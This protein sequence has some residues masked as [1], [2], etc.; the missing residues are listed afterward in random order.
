M[1]IASLDVDKLSEAK[2]VHGGAGSLVYTGLWNQDDFETP[3]FFVHAGYIP[4]G[5]GIGHHRH[6]E[7][8]EMF[9]ILD[10]S[11]QFTHN[12]RTTRAEGPAMVPC[13]KGESHAI[14][15]HT[16]RNTR[17]M[18][19]C[20]ANPGGGYDCTD[21]GEDMADAPLE[22]TDRIP[23]GRFGPDWVEMIAKMHGGKNEVGFYRVWEPRDFRT[24]W[25]WMDY[26]LIP[27]DASIGYHRHDTI[28][29][30]Y[31]LIEGSG[32]IAVDD[33]TRD[34]RQGDTIPNRLGG[35]H[36]IYNHTKNPLELLV[37]CVSMTKWVFD[38][39]DHGDDLSQR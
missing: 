22:S 29:E 1:R 34:V 30:C 11:A 36:G 18:N 31:I 14:Y 39:T 16:N 6:D 15:N 10:N 25:S 37:M 38:A 8:E 28:E 35:A 4:P 33:E 7:C 20:V 24:N 3:W 2:A 21:F 32:R 27:P 9:A 17:W 26:L 13:R 23:L 5:G 12:G 19:F